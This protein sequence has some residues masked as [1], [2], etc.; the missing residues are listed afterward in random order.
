MVAGRYVA[1]EVGSGQH[2]LEM[3]AAALGLQPPPH[4]TEL[5]L[6]RH[7]RGWTLRA[8][9][10]KA[11][12]EEVARWLR[13]LGAADVQPV[14]G[15]EPVVKATLERLTDPLELAAD[16]VDIERVGLGSDGSAFVLARAPRA[17]FEELIRHFEAVRL[18]ENAVP[19]LTARQAELLQY[20]KDHGYYAIPRRVT[21]R[22]LAKELGIS[23]TALSLALRRAEARILSAYVERLRHNLPRKAPAKRARRSA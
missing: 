11:Q 7:R 2:R 22:G 20:C 23:P 4:Y 6:A 5:S 14:A 16:I 9:A 12:A 8:L 18:P 15:K 19:E 1:V 10:G 17:R 13:S 21:L 3:P